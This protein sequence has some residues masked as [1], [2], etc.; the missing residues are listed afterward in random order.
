MQKNDFVEITIEDMGAKGE[1]IGKVDGYPLFV[2]GAIIGDRVRVK[3]TKANKNFGFARVSKM[4]ST[5]KHRV[6]ARCAVASPCG[7]CQL[8]EMDYRKQLEFKEKKVY[9]HLRR[10]GGFSEQALIKRTE[11]IIGMKNPYNYRNKGAFPF[12][13]DKTGIIITGFYAER[14][15]DIIPNTKCHIGVS[16][17]KRILEVVID[18]MKKNKVPPYDEKRGKGVIRHVLI[19]HG[20][21]TEETMVCLVVNSN[22]KVA[23]TNV[24]FLVKELEKVPGITSIVVNYN[25]Y[26]TNVI[27]GDK[28]EALWGKDYIAEILFDP[29]GEGLRYQISPLSFFQVNPIQTEKLYALALEYADL[30]GKEIVWDLYCGI[31]TISLFLSKRAKKVIGV[32]IVPQAIADAKENARINK[33]ENVEFVAGKAE[34][35]FREY[36]GEE[37][38]EEPPSYEIGENQK[39]FPEVLV[40]DP[41]RKGCDE[42]LLEAILEVK[43]ERIIYISCDSA[44]LARDLKILCEKEYKLTKV[45]PVDMFPMTVHVETVALLSKL[46]KQEIIL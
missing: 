42:G 21:R 1:G 28:W 20:F 23:L 22:K 37:L 43:P 2:K 5:S 32:E 3:I 24:N 31:G 26:K 27:M 30:K 34:E 7:G 44:T 9:E 19:R 41:P 45:R 12:G 13:V 25:V 6:E 29:E 4:I 38:L 11:P 40:L 18:Y 33:I 39:S 10:I 35:V 46:K 36:Y 8:Q 15:H 17:N 16:T 14:T